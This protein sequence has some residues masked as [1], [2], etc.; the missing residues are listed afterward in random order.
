M[1]YPTRTTCTNDV[2]HLNRLINV[3][4]LILKKYGGTIMAKVAQQMVSKVRD[5]RK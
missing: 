1:Y 2:H 4:K 3:F 5:Q